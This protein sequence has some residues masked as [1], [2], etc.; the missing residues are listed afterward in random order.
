MLIP[1]VV[2]KRKGREVA[3]DIFSRLLEDRII[4]IGSAIDLK[5][6]NLVVA[7]LLFLEKENPGEDIKIYINSPGGEVVAG[8]SIIDTMGHIKPDVSTINVGLA[9]SMAAAILACGEKGKRFV[10]PNSE[11]MIH[12]PIGGIEGQ[13]TD[14]DI[15]AKHAIQVRN[16]LYEILAKRTGKTKGVIEKD[17]DRNRWMSAKEAMDYGLVDKILK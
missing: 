12:Q 7:Q 13:V 2:E 4:F 11:T 16:R 8:M 14:I 9:A 3:Y 6:A 5:V 15:E 17:A 1:T 10:L